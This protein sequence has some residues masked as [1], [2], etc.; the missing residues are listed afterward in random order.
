MKADKIIKHAKMK[1]LFS[2]LAVIAAM[3]LMTACDKTLNPETPAQDSSQ[4][5]W[6]H[7]FRGSV[8][9]GDI[10]SYESEM[11]EAIKELF[12]LSTDMARAQVVFVG[13]SEIKAKSPSLLKAI[14]NDAFIVFPHYEGMDEDFAQMGVDLNYASIESDEY[15]PLL[16]CYNGYAQG[17][18][19]TLWAAGEDSDPE[20]F[21]ST[22]SQAE[23]DA[24]MEA[25][26]ALG[27][28][29]ETELETYVLTYYESCLAA[30]V[31][32]LE[33]AVA[34]QAQTK[35][36]FVTNMKGNLEQLGQRCPNSFNFGLNKQIDKGIIFP[37]DMLAGTGSIDVDIRVYPIFKQSSNGNNAGDYYIVV[38]RITPHNK[39]MW[40]PAEHKHGWSANRLYGYWFNGMDVVTS[41]VNTDGSAIRDIDYFERPIPENK[42]QSRQYSEGKSFNVGGT[43]SG[44]GG[45]MGDT[46][47]WS[48]MPSL[49]IGGGWSSS[50][51]YELSTIE[52]TV[53]SS[54]PSA[55][56][57]N[58]YTTKNVKMTDYW[59]NKDKMDANFPKTVR[60]DFYANTN[61]AWHVGSAKDYDTQTYMLKTKIDISYAA[62]HHWRCALEYDSNKKTFSIDV[63][64]FSWFLDAPNRVPWGVIAL[65]N[66]STYEMAHVTV[67]DSNGKQADVSTESFSK[68]Q[69]VKFSLPVGTYSI[70]FDLIDGTTRQKY[71]S[72][73]YKD[74]RVHQ[75]A[76][77]K[78]ATVSISTLDADELKS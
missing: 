70:H 47:Q 16:H 44:G 56:H 24:M 15:Y 6:W 33:G 63:P 21:E 37:P 8:Y 25:N 14:A 60:S 40:H 76:D 69:V 27:E 20:E 62:W 17:F 65:K 4:E 19:Y 74:I 75:G 46:G 39:E 67:Y 54:S 42:N 28:V 72:F 52:F 55:V 12:P 34:E 35:A 45:F 10:L 57:Y 73:V 77:E 26:K 13:E 48:L 29:E 1:R 50:T 68:D 11:Q 58:Y 71:G 53:D 49:T 43:I 22:W 78:S 18:T 2:F 32:W 7:Y 51:N 23:W 66:A 9:V 5:F 36:D 41:L 38:S 59:D 30:F 3:V 64:A 61:W 31:E